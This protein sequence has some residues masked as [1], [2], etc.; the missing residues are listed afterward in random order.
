MSCK[1]KRHIMNYLNIFYFMILF[2]VF[3]GLHIMILKSCIWYWFT[4]WTFWLGK[5]SGMN[6][7]VDSGVRWDIYVKCFYL[8]WMRL[9]KKIVQTGFYFKLKFNQI[10]QACYTSSPHSYYIILWG[11]PFLFLLELYITFYKNN[12]LNLR[13]WVYEQIWC[14]TLLALLMY[15]QYRTIFFDYISNIWVVRSYCVNCRLS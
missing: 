14:V 15:L 8:M 3:L 1:V 10:T 9:G 5:W 2:T 11:V 13:F 7:T 12:L 4:S 6:R